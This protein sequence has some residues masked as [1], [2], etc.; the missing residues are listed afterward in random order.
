MMLFIDWME[1]GMLW[2][3][4]KVLIYSFTHLFFYSFEQI[5]Q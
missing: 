5:K 2:N 4:F 1:Y 3:E